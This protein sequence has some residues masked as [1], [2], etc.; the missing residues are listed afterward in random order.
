MAARLAIVTAHLAIIAA[1][2]PLWQP[3]GHYDSRLAIMTAVWPLWQP[4]GHY[5]SRV[6]IIAPLWQLSSRIA[7]TTCKKN[8]SLKRLLL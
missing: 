8:P 7:N 3:S 2:W 6:A 5:D 4:S 1:V